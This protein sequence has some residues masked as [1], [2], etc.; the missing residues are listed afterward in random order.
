MSVATPQRSDKFHQLRCQP[1][2]PWTSLKGLPP[3]QDRFQRAIHQVSQKIAF[4]SCELIKV[5]IS[6]LRIALP[7]VAFC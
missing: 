1:E 6:Q 5:R 2:A 3:A 4:C 7:F